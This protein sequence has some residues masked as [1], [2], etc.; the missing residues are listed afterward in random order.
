MQFGGQTPLNLAVPLMRAGAP[1]IGTSPDSIDRA[2][3]RDRFKELLH[4]PGPAPARERHR[5]VL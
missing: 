3:D 2:E 1:I 5:Q 4:T